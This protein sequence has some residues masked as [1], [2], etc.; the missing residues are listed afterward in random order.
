MDECKCLDEIFHTG[1][2][3]GFLLAVDECEDGAFEIT[4]GFDAPPTAGD[5]GT[6]RVLQ[7]QWGQQVQ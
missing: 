3:Y 4:F 5:G 2:E 7:D 6:W 1:R